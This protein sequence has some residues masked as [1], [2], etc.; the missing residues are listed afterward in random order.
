MAQVAVMPRPGIRPV[1]WESRPWG[2]TIWWFYGD[3]FL[4]EARGLRVR[5]WFFGVEVQVNWPTNNWPTP[6]VNVV[7]RW[8]WEQ[9]YDDCVDD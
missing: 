3:T 9:W 2:V 6:D 8:W 1:Y 7:E 4:L 5:R